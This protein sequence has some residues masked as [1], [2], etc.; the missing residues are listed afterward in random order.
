MNH[1]RKSWIFLLATKV[2]YCKIYIELY[3][4]LLLSFIT[5]GNIRVELRWIL[6]WVIYCSVFQLHDD[7]GRLYFECFNGR[8]RTHSTTHY[9][10]AEH[11][12]ILLISNIQGR[13]TQLI[14]LI[15]TTIN[16]LTAIWLYWGTFS[17][18]YWY[19][20]SH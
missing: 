9:Y 12:I 18:T 13:R 2:S 14:C 11:I 8:R 17:R 4:L 7:G 10:N 3:L 19:Q 16:C 6:L 5:L 20:I 15:T 1:A